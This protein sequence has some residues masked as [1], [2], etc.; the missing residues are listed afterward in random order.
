MDPTRVESRPPIYAGLLP[1]QQMGHGYGRY[2]DLPAANLAV[3]VVAFA[4]QYRDT[5]PRTGTGMCP[6]SGVSL[7]AVPEGR[8][9]AQS[10][11]S[12]V[13]ASVAEPL[14]RWQRVLTRN[15]EEFGNSWGCWSV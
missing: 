3:P 13:P 12:L 4:D 9:A 6:R 10:G 7:F 15:I 2:G 11:H 5:P 14:V 1:D 8:V